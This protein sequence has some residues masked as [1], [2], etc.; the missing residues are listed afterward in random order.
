MT[1]THH[2]ST[3][4]TP[5]GPIPGCA[6]AKSAWHHGRHRR[7]AAVVVIAAAAW[8]GV[9]SAAATH[10]AGSRA[11]LMNHSTTVARPE[12]TTDW[13]ARTNR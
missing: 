12:A 2:S 10:R 11:Q 1:T 7:L 9:H 5:D 13:L 8:A 4:T 3:G 6:G